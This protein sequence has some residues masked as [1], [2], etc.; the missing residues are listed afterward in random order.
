MGAG[1]EA[2]R[3]GMRKG[4]SALNILSAAVQ[5]RKLMFV[6][7]YSRRKSVLLLGKKILGKSGLNQ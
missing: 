4:E 5:G 7:C 2:G 3:E 6:N 1:R